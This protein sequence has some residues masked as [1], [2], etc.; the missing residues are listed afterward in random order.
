M[1]S[2]A[3]AL[4]F[5]A[6]FASRAAVLYDAIT[7]SSTTTVIP[8]SWYYPDG[9]DGD[10]HS[11]DNFKINQTADVTDVYWRADN[12]N[13]KNFTVRF[14]QD[15]LN[16]TNAYQP[17]I[18]QLPPDETSAGY[19]YGFNVTNFAGEVTQVGTYQWDYHFHL[20]TPKR[21]QGTTHYWMKVS[22]QTYMS[23]YQAAPRDGRHYAYFTGGPYF[24]YQSGDMA[25]RIDGNL[26]TP[27]PA[28]WATLGLGELLLRRRAK[29]GR[30]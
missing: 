7:G 15:L 11:Y 21:F 5:V 25:F 12:P 3:F 23:I 27:E 19:L 16:S 26:L 13:S 20:P 6:P 14:Y 24:L 18:S 10:V 17:K 9:F 2:I 29:S 8:A 1:K 28:T 22:S 30:A 4:L